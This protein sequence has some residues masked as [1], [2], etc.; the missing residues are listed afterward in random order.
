MV[1]VEIFGG[2]GHERRRLA[3]VQRDLQPSR[4]RFRDLILDSED[5]GHV[6]VVAL[7]PEM[8][9]IA[10]FHQLD[11]DPEA[12][13]SL[14]DAPLSTIATLSFA[15]TSARSTAR[16]RNAM[17]DVRAATRRPAS[18]ASALLISSAIPSLRYSNSGSPLGFANGK[19]AID[20]ASAKITTA[21][22]TARTGSANG[23]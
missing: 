11:G 3:A 23:E 1:G 21:S 19:T 12:I 14:A 22:S 13:P 16:P 8:V 4:D 17:D 15:P 10:H 18:W 6:A 7:R 5:V 20:S 2:R 9:A